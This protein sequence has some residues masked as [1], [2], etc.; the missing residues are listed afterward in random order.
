MSEWISVEKSMPNANIQVLAYSKYIGV[1][2]AFRKNRELHPWL[3][4]DGDTCYS[5]VTHWMQ[6]PEPPK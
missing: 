4:L 3:Y 6:L 2:F 5:K 1:F